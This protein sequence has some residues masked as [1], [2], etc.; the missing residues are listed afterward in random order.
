MNLYLFQRKIV[1]LQKIPRNK[2]KATQSVT[3]PA[4]FVDYNW[5]NPRYSKTW[6]CTRSSVCTF[7]TK[8]IFVHN[9]TIMSFLN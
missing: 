3:L 8:L 1:Y 2:W 4:L 9:L 5:M 6:H 7:G